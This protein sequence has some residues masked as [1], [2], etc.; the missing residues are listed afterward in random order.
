MDL[1]QWPRGTSECQTDLITFF[2][3]SFVVYTYLSQRYKQL[4]QQQSQ[5][6]HSCQREY[7]AGKQHIHMSRYL[8][9]I[10]LHVLT[11]VS[12][13][14]HYPLQFSF[15]FR[16]KMSFLKC[17]VHIWPW[18]ACR[19]TEN[20]SDKVATAHFTHLPHSKVR[21]VMAA[22]ARKDWLRRRVPPVKG[23]PHLA[24]SSGEGIPF[25]LLCASG[26]V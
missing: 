20:A 24:Q 10:Q 17:F 25:N 7:T 15:E 19:L 22:A 21:Y 3:F 8:H 9:C 12:P 6:I 5:E 4:C 26:T 13:N 11:N 18:A 2:F 1:K 16:W 14:F 23:C